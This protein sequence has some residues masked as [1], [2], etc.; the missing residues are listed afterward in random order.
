MRKLHILVITALV[1]GL[2]VAAQAQ[3]TFV[4]TEMVTDSNDAA[5]W[6]EKARRPAASGSLFLP[7]MLSRTTVTLDYSV[8]L[9]GNI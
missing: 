4:T 3:N 5:G 9:A 7:M 2:G 1:L 6:V 8:P